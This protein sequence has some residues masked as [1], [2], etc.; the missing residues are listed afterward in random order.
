MTPSMPFTMTVSARNRSITQHYQRGDMAWR[1]AKR[2]SHL[3]AL[4]GVTQWVV[5]VSDGR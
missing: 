2:A 5:T 1:A 4:A 3:L